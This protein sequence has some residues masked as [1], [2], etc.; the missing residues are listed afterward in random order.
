LF[1]FF[2]NHG[3]LGMN[4]R[5]LLYIKPFN[6]RKAVAFADDK[7]RTKAFLSA[8][9]IPVAKIYARI[10]DHHQL[11]TF[12]FNQ[13]PDSCVLK[14]NYGFGGGGIM[15]LKGR[16]NG[17]FLEGGKRPISEKALREHIEDILD[18]KYSVNG[19]PDTAFFEKIL[20]SD[21]AFAPFRP[22]GLPDIRIV[23]FNLVPVMSM[24]RIPTVESGGKAN[25]HM[26]GF[27]IGIDIAKGVTTHAT[28]FNKRIRTLPSGVSPSGITIPRWEEL[29]LIASKIQYTTNIG[30][31]A[32]DLTLD[33]EQGPVLLE[34]NAR[35]GLMV[36]VANLAPLRSRLERVAGLKVQTPEKG[37]SL[38][39][40]LF[41]A[42]VKSRQPEA[43][44]DKPL[45]GMR[46]T[47]LVT[48]AG[49][50]V[51][52]PAVISPDQERTIFA[53]DLLQDLKKADAVEP[54]NGDEEA[55]R[56]KF[57]LGGKKIQ[58][59]VH[60]GNVQPASV[61][62][63]I[64][65]RDLVGFLL[66]PSKT[67]ESSAVRPTMKEDLRAIDK[68][69]SQADE[70]LMLLKHV[71]PVNLSEEWD[72]AREDPLYNPIFRY[73]PASADLADLESRLI[74]MTIDDSP[75]GILFKK[76]RRE[77]LQRITLVNA[78]G[79]A[80][81]FTEASSS[82]LG[83]PTS[84]LITSAQAELRSRVACDLPTPSAGMIDAE[85]AAKTFE[86]VLSHYGLHD[87]QVVVREHTIARCTVGGRKVTLRANARFSKKYLPALIAHEI[88]THVLTAENGNH[89]PFELFRRGFANYL[90]TQEG[91]AIY[92]QNRF[93]TPYHE[94]RSGPARNILAVAFALE[95]SFVDLRR[96]LEEELEYGFEKSLSKA[97]EIKRGLS[98]TS[99]A[100]GFTKGI[101][102]FRGLRAI[103]QYLMQGGDLKRLYIG[104]IALEDLELLEGIPGIK[105]PIVVPS[106]L[107]DDHASAAKPKKKS[108]A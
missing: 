30:Y 96:Y 94:K 107:H 50:N 34:V 81:R 49:T 102:Y 44:P 37:V 98:D 41:G 86:D 35:A 61:R 57:T 40:D 83:V 32:V 56:V 79:D 97:I 36:Q 76:K 45:L 69:L 103:E 58:T 78:R 93:L 85:E 3:V 48:G 51:E 16:K 64:G 6:P 4:A 88:E 13:L 84:V 5:N 100:G 71:K 54:E 20:V 12:D 82:L 8:R 11:R 2:T 59:V 42:K 39:Q 89:Q 105:Q 33:A 21:P 26:G 46:E 62:A 67:A 28:Q 70:E 18:G 108:K 92:N 24:L 80:R 77:L 25:V 22:A 101:V 7:L 65:R 17:L 53:S 1:P 75:V 47:L 9:G 91:L 66:D 106:F 38:A 72:K 99:E 15:I 87:W 43:T 29:L 104:K 19:L 60:E 74:A 63:I 10:E 90:D 55:F 14:P 68:L 52:V 95:H 27:G 23:V 31:L 73:A